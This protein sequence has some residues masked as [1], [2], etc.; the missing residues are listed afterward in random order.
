MVRKLRLISL[1]AL[2]LLLLIPKYAY[3][4][5][6]LPDFPFDIPAETIRTTVLAGLN[7]EFLITVGYDIGFTQKD[8]YNITEKIQLTG[9]D[10]G[11]AVK[12]LW[13]SSTE[14]IWTTRDRFNQPINVSVQF[15]GQ[16]GNN[17][18]AV[19][20]GLPPSISK[21][22]AFRGNELTWFA[23]WSAV[24]TPN[25]TGSPAPW[26]H[27]IGHM[28]GNYDEYPGGGVNPNKSHGNEPGLMGL[29][30]GGPT[31]TALNLF[32]R[33]Y[34]FVANWAFGQTIAMAPEPSSFLLIASGLVG[35]L[36]TRRRT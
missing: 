33:Q 7:N 19:L 10:P 36:I 18:I 8:G 5:L 35:L 13:K 32:D 28:F 21:P 23:G 3:A 29:S 9:V 22:D 31:G 25:G 17:T 24:G 11:P 2:P 30:L 16:G 1:C 4:V 27:E 26:V 14:N 6:L 20:P 15:V 12:D 34:Q